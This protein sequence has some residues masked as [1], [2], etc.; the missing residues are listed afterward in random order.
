MLNLHP[1]V[2]PHDC[3]HSHCFLQTGALCQR[4]ETTR[5]RR[6]LNLTIDPAL[7]ADLDAWAARQPFK[8]K[9]T[10]VIETAIRR[11]L[12]GERAKEKKG[13]RR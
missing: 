13:G 10:Q 6:P 2:Y 12:D 4:M 1:H 3:A 8:L 5:I 9:R 11:L 7:L